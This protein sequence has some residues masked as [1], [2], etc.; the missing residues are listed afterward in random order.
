M[1]D[2]ME[3]LNKL[4]DEEKELEKEIKRCE[5]VQEH[6]LIEE[7]VMDASIALIKLESEKKIY[8]H[9]KNLL[10]EIKQ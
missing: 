9:I 1:K 6:S 5:F 2:I 7:D 4:D 3:I 8:K 10:K